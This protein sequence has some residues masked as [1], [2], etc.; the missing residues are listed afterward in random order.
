M[1][2]V[3]DIIGVGLF[4]DS[5]APPYEGVL[6]EESV[7]IDVVA[8]RRMVA[9]VGQT[10]LNSK[11]VGVLSNQRVETYVAVTACVLVGVTFV[12]LNPKFP[13]ARLRRI[14]ELGNVDTILFDTSTEKMKQELFGDL[15]G[16]NLTEIC[17]G[18]NIA[19]DTDA[20]SWVSAALDGLLQED[21]IAYVM[22][23][24]GSTGDPK[25]VPVSYK[26]L[27][28]YVAGITELLDI[29]QGLRFTQFFD[30]SFDLSMHDIFISRF[31]NGTLVAPKPIDSLMPAAYLTREQI[32]VWFSVPVLGAILGRAK[33]KD[34]YRGVRYMLFC[35][36]ALPM[37]TVI[38]CRVHLAEDG[39]L[40]NLYGPTEATIAFTA[41]DVTHVSAATGVASIGHCFGQNK[42]AL[43][44]GDEIV[45]SPNVGDEG[46]LLLGGP[47]V[48]GGYSLPV[49]SAFVSTTSSS[50]Y[51]SGD[52]VRI[53]KEGINYRGR[54]DSQIKWRGY[55]IELGEIESA[56][57]AEYGIK[58]V[59]VVLSQ[60]SEEPVIVAWCSADEGNEVFDLDRLALRLPDYMIPS[61]II[62]LA[63]I[64]LNVNGKID[65]PKLMN[66]S[67][68]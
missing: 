16:I 47:Q 66:M 62:S 39:S 12:P 18:E 61:R 63:E 28:S 23:T 25:G 17:T 31:L 48:F 5:T 45:E 55:R 38:S 57:R 37:E 33:R 43:L 26:N 67:I 58:T 41:A 64:P 29:P 2:I 24:S 46:E 21:H 42:V 20:K 6:G 34:S 68:D 11:R 9:S 50:Y 30:L 8:A 52:L 15:H 36:E 27:A 49:S 40:W 7:T 32:D 44:K 1:I 22:F 4:D 60:T 65:R 14:I 53:A 59:A 35:G 54:S 19:H 3:R 56:I 10:L 13:V 51:R